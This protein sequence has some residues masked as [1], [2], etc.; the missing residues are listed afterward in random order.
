MTDKKAFEH[1]IHQYQNEK[2]AVRK[3]LGQIGGTGTKKKE[4]VINI[5]FAVLVI[6]FFSFDVMRHALHMNIDFIPEL[7]SVEIALLMVSMKIIWMIHRQ[8][9]VEH[10]QFWILNTI[11]FQMNSTAARVRKIEKMLKEQKEP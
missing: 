10:F 2:E 4:K 5:V 6:L 1:E 8:Q 11:E 7:F 3:I 9:K